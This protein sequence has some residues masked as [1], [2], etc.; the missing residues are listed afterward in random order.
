MSLEKQIVI[1]KI[2][3]L[4][5]GAIQV[6]QA[7]RIVE[8]NTPLSETYERWVLNKGDDVS[9]QDPKVQAIANAIWGE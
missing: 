9:T 7:T 1:D 2:E 5:D 8:N 4:E 6:R 3:V